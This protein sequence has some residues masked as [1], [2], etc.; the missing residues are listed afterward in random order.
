ML[1]LGRLVV[2]EPVLATSLL[3][4]LALALAARRDRRRL[5]RAEWAAT[6]TVVA[7][8]A[9]FL[10]VGQPAGGQRTAGARRPRGESPGSPGR[11]RP[12][13]PSRPGPFRPAGQT[14]SA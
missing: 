5:R 13:V 12:A 4:A 14:K 9:V 11:R 7:G 2:N 8:L 10:M 1:G 6:L 3:L